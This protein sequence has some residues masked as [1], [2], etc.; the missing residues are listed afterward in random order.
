[1]T[2]LTQTDKIINSS[3]SGDHAEKQNSNLLKTSWADKV[4]Y[5]VDLTILYPNHGKPT[6]I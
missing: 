4:K 1:M 5:V 6:N 3:P 2:S